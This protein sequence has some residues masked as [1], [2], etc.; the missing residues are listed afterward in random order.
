MTDSAMIYA[1]R[2][3]R[4]LE[5]ATDADASIIAI[6]AQGSA[7]GIATRT[8][9]WAR[10]VAN[11]DSGAYPSTIVLERGMRPVIFAPNIFLPKMAAQY[12]PDLDVRFDKSGEAA[13]AYLAARTTPG[14]RIAYIGRTEMSQPIWAALTTHC[15]ARELFD[16]ESIANTVRVQRSTSEIVAHRKAAEIC[17]ELFERAFRAARSGKP[18]FQIRADLQRD[19]LYAGCDFASTWL[20]VQPIADYSRSL[21]AECRRVPK[22]GDQFLIGVMVTYEGCW[23]HGIRTAQLGEPNAQQSSV[24]EAVQGM[25]NAMLTHMLPGAPVAA[26]QSAAENVRDRYFAQKPT[27]EFRY[28]HALGYAYDDP[29]PQNAAP[30]PQRYENEPSY[31]GEIKFMA[32]QVFE[33]HPNVFVDG[34]AGAAL[35]DMALVTERGYELLT[36]YPRGLAIL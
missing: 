3:E 1:Q 20:T 16:F 17:D 30:F 28:G 9:A 2:R 4:L 18:V 19:A 36:Q 25:H 6:H 29:L 7:A 5:L 26:V 34:V 22:E 21:L 35:G 23:G 31:R 14:A 27:F 33:L 8:H 12:A 15:V 13:A 11:F 10:Y 24:Y 32:N